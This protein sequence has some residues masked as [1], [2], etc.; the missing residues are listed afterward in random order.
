MEWG[1]QRMEW[2]NKG[3]N[4]RTDDGIE[5]REDGMRKQRMEKENR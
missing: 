5:N 2:E 1:I 3:W 4:G